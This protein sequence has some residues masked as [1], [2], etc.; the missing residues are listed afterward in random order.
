MKLFTD[1]LAS[2]RYGSLVD[3]LTTKMAELVAA[4]EE[5]QKPGVLTLKIG[6]RPGK[7]G[8]M[9]VYDDVVLSLPKGEKGC[10][11]M[12]VTPEGSLQREDPRQMKL[13]LKTVDM[14]T[15]E[16]RSIGS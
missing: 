2:L 5:H 4:C 10:S 8:Q 11:I 13:G 15:G 12:F 1:T 7:A 6:L 14:D 9:E 16:L 3:E